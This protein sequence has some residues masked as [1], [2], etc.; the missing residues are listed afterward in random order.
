[1]GAL[2]P[3]AWP[4]ARLIAAAPGLLEAA[5]ILISSL[6]WERKRSGITYAGAE[7]LEAAIDK[8]EGKEEV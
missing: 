1:M 3:P 4:N 8:A 2:S 6:V 7:I 5:K